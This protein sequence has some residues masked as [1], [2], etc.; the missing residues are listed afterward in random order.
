MTQMTQM[1]QMFRSDQDG[2]SAP[3]IEEILQN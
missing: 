3:L 2:P 1:T